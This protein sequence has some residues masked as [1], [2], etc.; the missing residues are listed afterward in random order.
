MAES[1]PLDDLFE[2]AMGVLAEGPLPLGEL[3]ERLDQAGRLDV[4]RADGLDEEDLPEA[5]EDELIVTDAVWSSATDVLALSSYLTEGLD[6]THRLAA[7]EISRG[8]VLLTPDLVVLDWN[9]GD[10][11]ELADG[12]PLVH[13]PGAHIPGEDNATL[14]GPDGWLGGFAPG[15]WSPSSAMADQSGSS[16]RGLSVTMSTR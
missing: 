5:V 11:L 7:D 16:R 14:V 4:L 10:G 9:D 8:Q 3:V 12:R 15:T 1:T 6:L 13:Q 2:Y